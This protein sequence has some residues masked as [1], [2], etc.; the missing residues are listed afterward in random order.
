MPASLAG[1]TPDT[2]ISAVGERALLRHL[3]A[4]IPRGAGVVVGVG[5][6]AAAVETGSLTLVTTDC[7]VER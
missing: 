3:R 7:L 1:A 5:D 4:R 2:P 6:D